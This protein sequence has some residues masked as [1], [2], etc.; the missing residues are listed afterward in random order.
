MTRTGSL[1]VECETMAKFATFEVSKEL[2][3]KALEA[4]TLAASSGK[5]RRGVNE[6]TKAIERGIAKL[7]IL[8]EDVTPEEI[9]MHLPALCEEKEIPF[10]PVPS[11]EELG[12]ASGI[13]VGTSSLAITEEGEGKTLVAEIGKT[14]A[15]LKK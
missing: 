10:I 1:K 2:A 12:R 8:A 9:L 7:V 11:K 5:I 13:E 14:I 6:T 3:E 4:T 15:G